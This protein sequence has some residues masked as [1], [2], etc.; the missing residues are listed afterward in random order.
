MSRF[1]N[2]L[3]GTGNEQ[4]SNVPENEQDSNVPEVEINE[5]TRYIP[6]NK[7]FNPN[8]VDNDPPLPNWKKGNFTEEQKKIY[9]EATEYL[10]SKYRLLRLD[11]D[12]Q[13]KEYE[14]LRFEESIKSSNYT[15]TKVAKRAKANLTALHQGENP[16]DLSGLPNVEHIKFT[17]KNGKLWEFDYGKGISS[18]N[19]ENAAYS[20]WKKMQKEKA[21]KDAE[22]K[23]TEERDRKNEENE[24]KRRQEQEAEKKRIEQ[25]ET[26]KIEEEKRIVAEEQKRLEDERKRLETELGAS[27]ESLKAKY[28][29]QEDTAKLS[30][31]QQNLLLEEQNAYNEKVSKLNRWYS[32]TAIARKGEVKTDN[33]GAYRNSHLEYQ[34]YQK[35]YQESDI[36]Q[37]HK[38]TGGTDKRDGN[39][40]IK[41]N[42]ECQIGKL[43]KHDVIVYKS[44]KG[45]ITLNDLVKDNF[46][47]G[48]TPEGEYLVVDILG[49]EGK[50][51]KKE[52]IIIIV[53]K[54]DDIETYKIYWFN[55]IY[56]LS[57]EVDP[58]TIASLNNEK[59]D[60]ITANETSLGNSCASKDELN[61]IERQK[62]D[63]R[64]IEWFKESKDC[65]AK[66]NGLGVY[67]FPEK[68]ETDKKQ[69]IIDRNDERFQKNKVFLDTCIKVQEK[70]LE[71]AT[72]YYLQF[73]NCEKIF[74]PNGDDDAIKKFFK[75]KSKTPERKD[76]IDLFK[77]IISVSSGN[78]WLEPHILQVKHI[79]LVIN[80]FVNKKGD[81]IKFLTPDVLTEW[82]NMTD[83]TDETK[84]TFEASITP[85][86]KNDTI[87]TSLDKLIT[88]TAAEATAAEA[89]PETTEAA[90]P[91]AAEA[92]TQATTEA[93]AVEAEADNTN[94][95]N[96]GFSINSVPDFLKYK[97]ANII[98]NTLLEKNPDLNTFYKILTNEH[99]INF[100]NVL[101]GNSYNTIFTKYLNEKNKNKLLAFFYYILK[102]ITSLYTEEIT[103]KDY[104]NE[105]I[106]TNILTDKYGNYCWSNK[107]TEINDSYDEILEEEV[108]ALREDF[109]LDARQ[110]ITVNRFTKFR[111]P[112]DKACFLFH[113]VGTGKTIT[114]LSIAFS[115]FTD[116]NMDEKYPLKIL[117]HAPQG[118][119]QSSFMGDSKF[120]GCYTYN[121]V[122]YNQEITGKTSDAPVI[123][124]RCDAV[125]LAGGK[126]K[127]GK[128]KKYYANFIG[129]DYDQ[130]FSE[131]GYY[132]LDSLMNEIV[133]DKN[134]AK[135]TEKHIPIV[136]I[137]DEA[138]RFLTN[139]LKPVREYKKYDLDC[140][141]QQ[142]IVIEPDDVELIENNEQYLPFFLQLLIRVSTSTKDKIQ[143][144]IKDILEPEN[145]LII[146]PI[147][148]GLSSADNMIGLIRNLLNLTKLS[149]PQTFIDSLTSLLKQESEFNLTYPQQELLNYT[150]KQFF[151]SKF[152]VSSA[153]S[154]TLNVLTFAG[155][156]TDNTIQD[157]IYDFLNTYAT[158]PIHLLINNMLSLTENLM[159]NSRKGNALTDNRFLEIVKKTDQAIF[160]TGTPFQKSDN[161]II[162]IIWFLNNP[163]IN[164]SNL[165][166]FCQDVIGKGGNALFKPL[167]KEGA[168]KTTKDYKIWFTSFAYDMFGSVKRVTSLNN[169]KTLGIE[170]DSN[171]EVGT[172]DIMAAAGKMYL[173][174]ASGLLKG[175]TAAATGATG[176]SF[177]IGSLGQH[178]ANFKPGDIKNSLSEAALSSG[179]CTYFL[180]GLEKKEGSSR[181]EEYANNLIDIAY[182]KENTIDNKL[183]SIITS[184][185]AMSKEFG[186]DKDLIK[187]AAQ[188][189]TAFVGLSA[190]AT[191]L[192]Q[193]KRVLPTSK[194]NKTSGTTFKL[195][196]LDCTC[197]LKSKAQQTGGRKQ[198][199]GAEEDALI[200]TLT[201]SSEAV[202]YLF[203]SVGDVLDKIMRDAGGKLDIPGMIRSTLKALFDLLISI[204]AMT[205]ELAISL[206]NIASTAIMGTLE[207]LFAVDSDAVI[208]HTTPFISIY[209]YDYE[210]LPIDEDK[211]YKY[212][213]KLGGQ[214]EFPLISGK[215]NAD[216]NT[217][218]FPE[219]FVD[220]ILI[221]YTPDQLEIF[222]KTFRL[223]VALNSEQLF[224]LNNI[225][226][227]YN[228]KYNDDFKNLIELYKK[229]SVEPTETVTT[230]TDTKDMAWWKEKIAID[231]TNK[232]AIQSTSL[233][234][235]LDI[236]IPKKRGN[237]I[238]SVDKNT[239]KLSIED[240]DRTLLLDNFVKNKKEFYSISEKPSQEFDKKKYKNECLQIALN[241][242]E[243]ENEYTMPEKTKTSVAVN[244]ENSFH[245][246]VQKLQPINQAERPNNYNNYDTFVELF[247]KTETSIKTFKELFNIKYGNTIERFDYVLQLLLVIKC[248]MVY[249]PHDNFHLQAHY[250][251]E[252]PANG[253]NIKYKHYLPLV[254]P[255]TEEIMY[256]FVSYLNTRGYNYVWMCNKMDSN[257]LN[258]NF[259]VG[260]GNTYPI[261]DE[262]ISNCLQSTEI[263]DSNYLFLKNDL[264]KNHAAKKPICLIISPPHTEGF[265]FNYSPSLICLDLCRSSGDAE[266]V[267]G[268]I[269]R[270]YGK[271]SL[272]EKYCKKIYQIFGG[273]RADS[274]NL[275]RYANK[276]GGG[277]QVYKSIYKSI[278][279]ANQESNMALIDTL[280]LRDLSIWYTKMQATVSTF[281]PKTFDSFIANNSKNLNSRYGGLSQEAKLLGQMKKEKLSEVFSSE[282]GQLTILSTVAN[283]ANKYFK[284]L[285]KIENS[286]LE[287]GNGTMEFIP[288]D[289]QNIENGENRTI[290]CLPNRTNALLCNNSNAKIQTT[291]AATSRY[292]NKEELM[293]LVEMIKINPSLNK[294]AFVKLNLLF[295]TNKLEEL[296]KSKITEVD[297]IAKSGENN[298]YVNKTNNKLYDASLTPEEN[299]QI[300]Y[301]KNILVNERPELLTFINENYRLFLY[302][303]WNNEY[304]KIMRSTYDYAIQKGYI[305]DD[306][307][308]SRENLNKTMDFFNTQVNRKLGCKA[309]I[310]NDVNFTLS[311][312]FNFLKNNIDKVSSFI[313]IENSYDDFSIQTIMILFPL[314][315]RVRNRFNDIYSNGKGADLLR[316]YLINI[317]DPHSKHNKV[318]K[319]LTLVPTALKMVESGILTKIKDLYTYYIKGFVTSNN[320][321]GN[322]SDGRNPIENVGTGLDLYR[323]DGLVIDFNGLS[324]NETLM[325]MLFPTTDGFTQAD[326]I[327]IAKIIKMTSHGVENIATDD[328]TDYKFLYG[329][330]NLKNTA[331]LKTIEKFYKEVGDQLSI[332][333][334]E[335]LMTSFS[336]IDSGKVMQLVDYAVKYIGQ[337]VDLNSKILFV[338]KNYHKNPY[339][340][341]FLLNEKEKIDTCDS[342]INFMKDIQNDT[343]PVFNDLKKID[344]NVN[345][346]IYDNILTVF[347]DEESD[348]F[349][350]ICLPDNFLNLPLTEDTLSKI[351]DRFVSKLPLFNTPI[352]ESDDDDVI[353]SIFM[354]YYTKL[355][356]EINNFTYLPKE[357]I[358]TSNENAK[359]LVVSKSNNEIVLTSEMKSGLIIFASSFIQAK[360]KWVV[361]D[362]PS[363]SGITD[364]ISANIT[365]TTYYN[366]FVKDN[367]GNYLQ[368][369]RLTLANLFTK[370]HN[371]K[372]V[373][374]NDLLT[375]EKFTQ[376][377]ISIIKCY[378]IA[379]NNPENEL[380][381]FN[382]IVN[383]LPELTSSGG[384]NKF[385]KNSTKSRRNPRKH[386]TK[387][388]VI[389]N[390][391]HKKTKKNKPNFAVTKK[392]KKNSSINERLFLK[393]KNISK[394]N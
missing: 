257:I 242:K 274:E 180:S 57:K 120:M 80:S 216:G 210:Q 45:D 369:Y 326:R 146:V 6:V 4:D 2:N 77:K 384:F 131:N 208:K 195:D 302:N 179:V 371:I 130:L 186:F 265:S 193:L 287:K 219:K 112:K 28:L 209:N 25:E 305:K 235:I 63:A 339:L 27:Y 139:S 61:L 275:Q 218:A 391:K 204:P 147:L 333:K 281:L 205:I 37:P 202:Q 290:Y 115:H 175:T 110:Y 365:D 135:E 387:R 330:I 288:F 354:K 367:N 222:S 35:F 279:N 224:E 52:D 343:A 23:R 36:N 190:A 29:T 351:F 232:Y 127:K 67:F 136:M 338:F 215:V 269:L 38:L 355:F 191:A 363:G 345:N 145:Q 48:S 259:S 250:V 126:D 226:G 360:S 223:N 162:D 137:C 329:L 293:K 169:K 376:N 99:V 160:L 266:Q 350:F 82:L 154:S 79:I 187:S 292:F 66:L 217:F 319:Y 152:M 132:A 97:I 311:P 31:E 315:M 172:N 262:D 125:L 390:G 194:T 247:N 253:Q 11:T 108:F 207:Y 306:K 375:D 233:S 320:S 92:T 221:P 291:T 72:K 362:I 50:P 197:T 122:K 159:N 203:S 374:T 76:F 32:S 142:K 140:E 109:K 49:E 104:S 212:N 161:D 171:S 325:K 22:S 173:E 16:V 358:Q 155:Q 95:L 106:T 389:K 239:E 300:L 14:R 192:N 234:Y 178:V 309:L 231:E 86:E 394:M 196:D 44:N 347:K 310:K 336:N 88:A 183:K 93:K 214:L 255:P 237:T 100:L 331:G 380:R 138:H 227:C 238:S 121:F 149:E 118:I 340:H 51:I 26:A 105:K 163:E 166:N 70:I 353:K 276:Y 64:G 313:E 261:I 296:D 116:D 165:I 258:K 39:T 271:P 385:N 199:G 314:L 308:I 277:N 294:D 370:V 65:A 318:M 382:E 123:V 200:T 228:S 206:V 164:Q 40:L 312:H 24:I 75:L 284:E 393:N 260:K 134:K 71:T 174:S 13:K 128:N 168:W 268:R 113:G 62:N 129:I 83:E 30:P 254:Y 85:S 273:T 58:F 101:K 378:K 141:N 89:T 15:A 368:T 167:E 364:T 327:T 263:R 317:N 267:Y 96:G 342:Y 298:E 1:F 230:V 69:K 356:F 220:Q 42:N 304:F 33:F 241:G 74:G 245:Y 7:I 297:A 249:S 68:N 286:S 280:A 335:D 53:A 392:S 151:S 17:D 119:L 188:A 133:A 20:E 10:N 8:D 244:I 344:E 334:S 157:S 301:E 84:E 34:N 111:D 156:V 229:N 143:N 102:Q 55:K 124:D 256:R 91:T 98:I 272:N 251:K 240:K 341:N 213:L 283:L 316:R 348:L 346:K 388:Y 352:M 3:F 322:P 328:P 357:F 144:F 78:F 289:I 361:H 21:V 59:K 170:S 379:S 386:Y 94:L 73:I 60:L 303:Q 248:G 5:S 307:L 236:I 252:I 264:D 9:K 372:G 246:N 153:L 43:I 282:D 182:N 189:Q 12:E 181:F 323:S 176:V 278:D 46:P 56:S 337:N 359:K 54:K 198:R 19:E 373:V 103:I 41:W 150:I 117:I 243:K 177:I 211:F 324:E 349:K 185:K 184:T 148:N 107:L 87:K 201:N 90:T 225:A 299:L 47:A 114:S 285:T 158:T 383:K 332:V 81:I 18:T 321:I 377:I 366:N 295:M 381:K 270:K